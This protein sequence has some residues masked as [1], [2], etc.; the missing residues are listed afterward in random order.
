MYNYGWDYFPARL[1]TTREIIFFLENIENIN[2]VIKESPPNLVNLIFGDL[3]HPDVIRDSTKF[4][5]KRVD[6]NIKKIILEISS[7]K[8]MYYNDIPLN[9]F[10]SL[11]YRNS[12]KL[13]EKILTNAE[14]ETDLKRIIELC[15]SV[16]NENIEIHV[17]PHLNLKTKPTLNYIQGRNALTELLEYLCDKY[18]IKIHN[19]GKY[20]E[21][22]DDG[23]FLEDYMK[24]SSHYSKNYDTVKSFLTER[25]VNC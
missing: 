4:L 21:N 2:S 5:N 11:K 15:K 25:I 16:F 13:T 19:I 18:N 23:S 12:Y 22:T 9:H 17:I 6:K 8:V 1:H 20:I 10:Y 3:C 14:V 24:D 7:V